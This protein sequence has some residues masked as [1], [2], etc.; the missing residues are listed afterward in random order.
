[1]LAGIFSAIDLILE[2]VLIGRET[3]RRVIMVIADAQAHT[4]RCPVSALS[5][6][7]LEYRNIN[8]C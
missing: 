4:A 7:R 1:M 2:Q 5:L 6:P 8:T 3:N